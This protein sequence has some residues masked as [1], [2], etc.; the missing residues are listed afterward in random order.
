[1]QHCSCG[2]CRRSLMML[3]S[4]PLHQHARVSSSGSGPLI[5]GA[6]GGGAYGFDLR[7][8]RRRFC[9][10]HARM[11]C[12]S[13]SCPCVGRPCAL[14]HSDLRH[15]GH[16]LSNSGRV[17]VVVAFFLVHAR[18]LERSENRSVGLEHARLTP[19]SHLVSLFPCGFVLAHDH[20]T[21]A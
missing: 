19:N 11:L 13:I 10:S 3:Y 2:V 21:C 17:S 12:H 1:M 15:H 16:G 5:D 20:T 8:V 9:S 14:A 18:L 4:C 6:H 7:S